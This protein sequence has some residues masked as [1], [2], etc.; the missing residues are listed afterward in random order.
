MAGEELSPLMRLPRELRDE[1]YDGVFEGFEITLGTATALP[2]ILKANTRIRDEALPRFFKK[3]TLVLPYHQFG[4]AVLKDKLATRIRA[5]HQKHFA[6]I[7]RIKVDYV[8][9]KPWRGIETMTD[10]QKAEQKAYVAAVVRCFFENVDRD[11]GDVEMTVT[12][13]NS[14]LSGCATAF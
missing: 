2:G 13:R 3:T 7:E 12:M 11:L 1:I 8:W 6:L 14:G 5:L 4:F 10:E 9:T